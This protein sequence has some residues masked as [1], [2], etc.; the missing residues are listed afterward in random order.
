MP[1]S[2]QNWWF[3]R[4][5]W[6]WNLTDDLEKTIEHLFLCCFKLCAS[7]HSHHSIQTGVTVQFGS[8]SVHHF[9]AIIE[10]KLELQSN[11]GQNRWFFEP[12]DLEIWRITL[13]KHRAPLL[14]NI[15]LCALFHHHMWIQIG[16]TVQKQLSRVLTSVTL[17]LTS[18]LDLLHGQTDG[19]MKISVLRAAWLHLKNE[20]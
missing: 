5:V 8:K 15:K 6:P 18:D 20:W 12:C 13:K 7:F 4:P 16:V 10:F 3:F 2:G 19:Q 17:T 1:N 14:S 9:I 11:L